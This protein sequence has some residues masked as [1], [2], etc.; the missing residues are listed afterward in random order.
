V[1][2][3]CTAGHEQGEQASL[4]QSL[5]QSVLPCLFAGQRS[6]G[7][8]TSSQTLQCSYCSQGK[9]AFTQWHHPQSRAMV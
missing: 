4:H 3:C 8:S 6:A 2:L 9:Q 7:I 5:E 1:G